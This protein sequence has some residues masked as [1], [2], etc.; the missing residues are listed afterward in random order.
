MMAASAADQ[1]LIDA[2]LAKNAPRRFETGDT[3]DDW[4][5]MRF[6]ERKGHKAYPRLGPC[7]HLNV[8]VIDGK[9]HTRRAFIAFINKLRAAEG[10]PR[11][12]SAA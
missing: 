3:G 6:L 8:Y 2:F 5:L 1:A 9:P 12:G 11:I 10:K 7:K 4:N